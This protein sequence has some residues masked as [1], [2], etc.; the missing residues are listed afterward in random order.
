MKLQAAPLIITSCTTRKRGGGGAVV[1]PPRNYLDMASVVRAWKSEL[2][3]SRARVRLSELYG[4]RSFAEARAVAKAVHGDLWIVSAGLGLVPADSSAPPYNL[5]VSGGEGSIRPLL[6]RFSAPTSVWWEG[7]TS[8][9]RRLSESLNS[10]P[11]VTA[12]LALPSSYLELISKDLSA[13]HLDAAAN[14][15]IFT[16]LAGAKAVPLH[17]RS[18]VMPYDERLESSRL[19]GTQADFAQRALRHFV[20]ELDA[21]QLSVESATERVLQAMSTLQRR[22]LPPRSRQ[23]DEQV[24]ELIRQSWGACGGSSSRLLRHLRDDLQVSC[25][26]GRFS[27][28]WRGVRTEMCA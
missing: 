19:A 7:I 25:E 24:R 5:T 2:R 8:G 10:H 21:V 20:C 27:S 3:C 22:A 26:Q 14:L 13:V 23:T 17:L 12:L 15:R 4:G 28:L 16:S 9:D 11:G 18:C 1:L 6:K